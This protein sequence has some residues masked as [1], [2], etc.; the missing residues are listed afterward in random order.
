MRERIAKDQED[1]ISQNDKNTKSESQ[2]RKMSKLEKEWNE[3]LEAMD[4]EPE[5]MISKK[6]FPPD[7]MFFHGPNFFRDY[8]NSAHNKPIYSPGETNIIDIPSELVLQKRNYK[9][10]HDEIIARKLAIEKELESKSYSRK[11][12]WANYWSYQE[13]L[14]QEENAKLDAQYSGRNLEIEDEELDELEELDV[15]HDFYKK[16]SNKKSVGLDNVELFDGEVDDAAK[17]LELGMKKRRKAARELREKEENLLAST[18]EALDDTTTMS[19]LAK[20]TKKTRKVKLKRRLE[21]RI[22][23]VLDKFNSALDKKREYDELREDKPTEETLASEA[24]AIKFTLFDQLQ[25]EIR[26]RQLQGEQLVD[27][28]VVTEA[29]D[30]DVSNISYKEL[31]ISRELAKKIDD[32]ELLSAHTEDPEYRKQLKQLQAEHSQVLK[33]K[34]DLDSGKTFEDFDFLRE[35]LFRNDPRFLAAHVMN[36]TAKAGAKMTNTTQAVQNNNKDS[37]K[38]QMTIAQTDQ[39]GN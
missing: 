24:E 3:E 27:E 37:S 28:T 11:E 33:T 35:S 17:I 26:L 20:A 32:L 9:K 23:A 1:R 25:A 2:T 30:S 7:E 21:K 38:G 22:R 6:E 13:V 12:Y 18:N 34:L 19:K 14:E 8:Y 16:D 5:D 4:L 15:E 10:R 36:T 31:G 39:I 29:D